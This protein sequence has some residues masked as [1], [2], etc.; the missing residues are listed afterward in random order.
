MC[1][2]RTTT[3]TTT[4]TT[5]PTPVLIDSQASEEGRLI[6]DDQ[7]EGQSFQSALNECDDDMLGPFGLCGNELR[8]PSP[9]NDY[10]YSPLD[11][12]CHES[13][14]ALFDDDDDK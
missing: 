2:V 4:T 13:M 14:S 9:D 5:N 7:E 12:T 6:I 8:T 1:L 3:T 11:L 10:E